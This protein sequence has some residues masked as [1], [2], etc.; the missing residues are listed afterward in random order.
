[1]DFPEIDAREEE[2]VDGRSVASLLSGLEFVALESEACWRGLRRTGPAFVGGSTFSFLVCDRLEEVLSFGGARAM[3]P[4]GANNH[5]HL[6]L[7][8]SVME[9][10]PVLF[11]VQFIN[12]VMLISPPGN[13]LHR[14]AAV[15]I[16]VDVCVV[17]DAESDVACS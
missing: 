5:F 9:F 15:G 2:R 17:V 4:L 1:M 11:V 14:T 10:E 12:A 6:D 16:A 13:A 7:G 3:F 8:F